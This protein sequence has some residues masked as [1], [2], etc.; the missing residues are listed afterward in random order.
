MSKEELLVIGE[1]LAAGLEAFRDEA[2]MSG[3]QFRFL[4]YRDSVYACLHLSRY[5]TSPALVS[6]F[7][8]H[9]EHVNDLSSKLDKSYATISSECSLNGENK[10]IGMNIYTRY[11]CLRMRT[12]K[13]STDYTKEMVP[14][15]SSIRN[16]LINGASKQDIKSYL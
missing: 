2:S 3:Y 9:G 13:N 15:I 1:N 4:N 6:T 5:E 11:D 12:P 14:D 16:I 8:C 10:I 7:I